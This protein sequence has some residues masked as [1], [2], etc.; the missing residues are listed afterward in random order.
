MVMDGMGTFV[1]VVECKFFIRICP[2]Q[3]F[4]W[5]AAQRHQFPAYSRCEPVSAGISTLRCERLLFTASVH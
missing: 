4:V 1:L 2:R 5:F 3:V